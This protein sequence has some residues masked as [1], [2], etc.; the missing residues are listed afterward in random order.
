MQP[1]GRLAVLRLVGQS[2]QQV[3][4]LHPDDLLAVGER[5]PPPFAAGTTCKVGKY[6][7]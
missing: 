6:P 7:R 3:V 5:I 4:G 2:P 1:V